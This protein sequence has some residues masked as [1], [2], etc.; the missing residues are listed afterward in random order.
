MYV[1]YGNYRHASGEVELS[2]DRETLYLESQQPWAYKHRWTL[3]GE[4]TGDG[5]GD[6]DTKVGLLEQAYAVD[7]LDLS[8]RKTSGAPTRLILPN[9][10]SLDGVRVTAPPQYPSNRGGVYATYIPYRIVLEAEYPIDDPGTIRIVRF[11]ESLQRSGGGPLVNVLETLEGP[12]VFQRGKLYPAY[13]VVQTGEATGL[14]GYPPI[15]DPLWP[16]KQIRPVAI[17]QASPDRRG[18]GAIN[19]TVTWSYE[20]ASATP[21]MG[22][23][24]VQGSS[25]P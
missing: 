23:P 3:T 11:R 14:F 16:D 8:L 15:P 1:Q 25:Y 20:F 21:L 9:A 18:R 7:G 19:Y 6:I 22:R 13:R 2:I 12:P 10:G 17:T 5:Q 4:L 24:H